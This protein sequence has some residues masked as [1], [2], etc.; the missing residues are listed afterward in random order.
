MAKNKTDKPYRLGV[1]MVLFNEQG[2][3][4]VGRRKDAPDPAWQFPQGGIDEGEDPLA[5]VW[6]EMAEEIGTNKAQLLRES[7]DWL[8]YDLPEDIA[9]KC[10]GGKYRGQKQMWY[11]FRFVGK[12][13]DIDLNTHNPEFSHWQWVDLA[14]VVDLVVPFKHALY[15]QVVAEFLP[16]A[17]SL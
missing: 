1:G 17:G 14:S 2:Q 5:A 4:F 16:L 3:V 12:D 9:A 10:W 6:R 11:A 7:G 13:T 8:A 15:Q